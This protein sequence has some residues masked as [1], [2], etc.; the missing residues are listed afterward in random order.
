MTT[1]DGTVYDLSALQT[2]DEMIGPIIDNRKMQYYINVCSINH[3]N[4]KCFDANNDP[5]LGFA[6]Q[7][8][9]ICDGDRCRG[10]NLGDIIGFFPL[11]DEYSSQDGVA[12]RFSHG[13]MCNNGVEREIKINFLCDTTVGVGSPEPPPSKQI[14]DESQA[15]VYELVWKSIYAC[16]V[17]SEDDYEFTYTEC[18]DGKRQ[19]MARWKAN[20]KRC[21]DGVGLPDIETVEDGCTTYTV[22]EP[23]YA[24]DSNGSCAI[25]DAGT[26]SNG[27]ALYYKNLDELPSTFSTECSTA[28]CTGFSV[29]HG[30]LISGTG[31]SRLRTI[32]KILFDSTILFKYHLN[33]PGNKDTYFSFSVD[34]EMLMV[35][36]SFTSEEEVEVEFDITKGTH[37]IE[38][39]FM[40]GQTDLEDSD[41]AY[42]TIKSIT[43]GGGA[44]SSFECQQCA[45]GTYQ[46]EKGAHKCLR[47]PENTYSK[48]GAVNY[49]SCGTGEYSYPGSRECDLSVHC[50]ESDYLRFTTPC[51]NETTQDYYEFRTPRY[52]GIEDFIPPTSIPR[53][54]KCPPGLYLEGGS[55]QKCPAG[56]YYSETANTCVSVDEGYA[57]WTALTF[58]SKDFGATS[59]DLPPGWTTSCVGECIDT[60]M[61]ISAD[62]VTPG[63]SFSG[64]TKRIQK[65]LS[66]S[67]DKDM[68][69]SDGA[70]MTYKTA[71]AL[72]QST[73]FEIYVDGVRQTSTSEGDTRKVA[74]PKTA[75]VIALSF[76]QSGLYD[77]GD[78]R[79]RSVDDEFSFS[80]VMIVG[81]TV[82]S[83]SSYA[84]YETTV[85]S[86]CDRGAVVSED[87]TS[88]TPCPKGSYRSGFQCE[89]CP[90]NTYTSHEGSTSCYSCLTGTVANDDHTECIIPDC[91]FTTEDETFTIGDAGVIGPIFFSSTEFMYLSVCE[92]TDSFGN[93]LAC[94]SLQTHVC[95][96]KTV[97][98]EIGLST[99]S[100]VNYGSRAE[101]LSLSE[102]QKGFMISY[103]D[104]SEVDQDCPSGRKTQ[105]LFICNTETSVPRA[106]STDTCNPII[107]WNTPYGCPLCNENT[108]YEEIA[109]SCSSGVRVVK[110]AKRADV[111]CNGLAFL[112]EF[113]ESCSDVTVPF[114]LIF[115]SLGVMVLLIIGLLVAIFRHRRISQKYNKLVE[116]EPEE[117]DDYDFQ[118][119]DSEETDI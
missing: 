36:Y 54:C 7:I 73:L 72:P 115:I 46:P 84:S 67:V 17:C 96:E 2:N 62:G 21:H 71:G 31:T 111:Q 20:P 45:A 80:D 5:I 100:A 41:H 95:L 22:C 8:T 105:V 1:A 28:G 60:G 82:G 53:A 114:S 39:G 55:C 50:E 116:H 103:S 98:D 57:A 35:D 40:N 14:E 15:C 27:A 37:I 26:Y 64:L 87:K 29:S 16:P 74:L 6:C 77:N 49:T 3:S 88:C 68:M 61:L 12:V 51:E 99:E 108:D 52:C 11:S 38:W 106:I 56:E 83:E 32:S 76:T 75:S 24:V 33:V 25:C 107:Y 110:L 23:G 109:G 59:S 119:D 89:V 90:E 47:S 86:E 19:K 91:T 18:V 44:Y 94:N 48:Q 66:F 117:L 118:N 112:T 70:F 30:V 10:V 104:P 69:L 97:S 85:L 13:T 58:F 93:D 79:R 92:Q 9:T 101:F 81:A 102:E 65:V 113:K 34:G 78:E 4:S 42:V 43:I 63:Y